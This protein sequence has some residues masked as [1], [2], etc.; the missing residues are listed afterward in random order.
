MAAHS[1]APATDLKLQVESSAAEILVHC[2]GK[3]TLSTTAAIQDQVHP[4]VTQTKRIT[5]DLA[6]VSY[7]D[8]A[9]LGVIVRLW[10]SAQ[11]AG[12]ALKITNLAPRIKE[13]LAMTNLSS[14]FEA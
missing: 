5:L 3:I 14:I 6:Q 13:L 10:S 12:C 11:K 4:L 9:G 2:S 7:I 8:S 1:S